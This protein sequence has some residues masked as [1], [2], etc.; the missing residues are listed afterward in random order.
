M[1]LKYCSGLY[2]GGNGYQ[3][4]VRDDGFD[5]DDRSR[6]SGIVFDT[7]QSISRLWTFINAQD[8][9]LVSWTCIFVVA[10][11]SCS[12]KQVLRFVASPAR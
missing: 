3:E 7:E 5:P 12:L 1:P 10:G 6:M 8:L 4:W 2:L 9:Y 11:K